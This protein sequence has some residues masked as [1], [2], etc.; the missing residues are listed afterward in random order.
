MTVVTENYDKCQFYYY[1]YL[2]EFEIIETPR[3]KLRKLNQ[4]VFDFVFNKYTNQELQ[5]FLALNSEE[6]IQ[7][8]KEKYKTGFSTFNKTFL[9]FQIIDKKSDKIIG[10]CGYHTWYT[11]HDRA[12]IGYILF[13]EEAKGKGYMTEVM[14]PILAYGFGEMN[15]HRVEAFVGK[16]NVPSLKLMSNF[17]FT[18]EG[19]LK[20]HYLKNGVYEDSLVFALLR[21]EFILPRRH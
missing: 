10:W 19:H 9:Y 16:E 6:D 18:Q 15:L 8:E 21:S 17:G 4:E 12:E 20:E 13:D 14:T 2:M 3:L 1:I 7:L 11:S 5:R